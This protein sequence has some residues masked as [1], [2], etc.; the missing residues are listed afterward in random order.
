V[1]H[2][3]NPTLATCI[4]REAPG[5]DERL[6]AAVDQIDTG[7]APNGGVDG[8]QCLK[9]LAVFQ[10][11]M[12]IDI[13]Q[14]QNKTA[15]MVRRWGRPSG[16]GRSTLL[17]HSSFRETWP[18]LTCAVDHPFPPDVTLS[19]FSGTPSLD[20]V[21]SNHWCSF[22]VLSFVLFLCLFF[23]FFLLL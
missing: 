6:S 4:C 20:P 3:R 23:S 17:T 14:A 11:P 10:F 8:R 12:L 21:I 9:S 15:R 16:P 1:R 19:R 5:N 22:L 13:L 2:L 18:D 7:F